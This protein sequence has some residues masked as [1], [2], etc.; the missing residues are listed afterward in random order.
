VHAQDTQC[1]LLLNDVYSGDDGVLASVKGHVEILCS[2]YYDQKFASRR[3]NQ[4]RRVVVVRIARCSLIYDDI[5]PQAA[6]G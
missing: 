4:Q 6:G 2:M 3:N 1:S 5:A